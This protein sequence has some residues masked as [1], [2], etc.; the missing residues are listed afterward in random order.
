MNTMIDL[1]LGAVF[2]VFYA[3]GRFNTPRT[4]RSSTTAGRYFA[5]L[6]C[7]VLV[8]L[9]FYA[10][11]VHFPHL[12][13]FALQGDEAAVTPWA[14]ELS[15]P[16]LVAL[17][18]TVLLPKLPFLNDL[19]NWI[20]K[21]LQDMA[22]IPYEVRRLSA[23]LRKGNLEVPDEL[24]AEVRQKLEN[25][26]FSSRDICFDGSPTPVRLWTRL[27][28][29]LAKLEDWESDRK[30]AGY[31]ATCPDEMERLRKR[32]EQLIPKAKMCFHLLNETAAGPATSRTHE[33][34]V[35]YQEDFMDLLV[36][37][38]NAVLDF[39]GRG[40]LHAELTDSARLNRLRALGFTVEWEACSFTFNQVMLVFGM[41]FSVMLAGGVI[42]SGTMNGMTVGKML[43]RLVM[44]ALIYCVAIACAV[45]PKERWK[46]ARRQPGQVRPVG[47]YIASGFLAVGLSQL[48][49][50]IF[51]CFL[52]HGLEGGWQR[53]LV[54]YP[55]SLSTLAT[56]VTMGVLIDNQV[57][58]RWA[59]WQQRVFEGL[60]QGLVMTSISYLVH[61][62][63]VE[64]MAQVIT[65]PAN[66]R[67]PDLN[68]VMIMAGII[69]FVLGYCIPTWCREAPRSR[70]DLRASEPLSQLPSPGV[71][72]AATSV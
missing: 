59:R 2:V 19:D 51:S 20:R 69:G 23:Q 36:E 60:T 14:K 56:T 27:A 58:P 66:Y 22:A 5:A 37:L 44:I 18:L 71:T 17:L 64:R 15:R 72:L 47:F 8:G 49:S 54:T 10:T 28:V 52:M 42:F 6:I 24:Q 62:W 38:H 29:L 63:L 3:A 50:F 40:V 43:T 53:F 4:N 35:G 33:A 16:L 70:A 31:L 41:V 30:M 34:V 11:L 65:V 25:S 55:W 45:F 46:F 21:C 68:Q 9:V 48:V 61:C 26:G 12:F 7:Y 32:Y 1:M 67:V 39:I 13:A 57:F